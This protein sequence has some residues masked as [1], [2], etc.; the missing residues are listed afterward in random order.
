[1]IKFFKHMIFNLRDLWWMRKMVRAQ[2]LE[3]QM[4]VWRDVP[5]DV[6]SM[7]ASFDEDGNIP[8]DPHKADWKNFILGARS[9]RDRRIRKLIQE[10]QAALDQ[11]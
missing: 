7:F 4:H 2:F 6:V 10:A 11:V 1:M 9:E 5:N 8:M 3:G